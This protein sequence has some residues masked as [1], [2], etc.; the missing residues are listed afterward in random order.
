[1]QSDTDIV[2]ELSSFMAERVLWKKLSTIRG[3]K[4]PSLSQVIRVSLV[5]Q[6]LKP[7]HEIYTSGNY[8][9]TLEKG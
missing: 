4:R 8:H 9:R 2:N 5:T 6:L 1:M 7:L 3:A